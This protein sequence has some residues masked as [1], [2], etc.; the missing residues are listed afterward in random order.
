MRATAL[1]P[2]VF[3]FIVNVPA[4]GF[5]RETNAIRRQISI[6]LKGVGL[7]N[8]QSLIALSQAA[9]A[10]KAASCALLRE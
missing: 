5:V 2:R 9:C 8:C 4:V 6:C 1:K 3:Q 10:D 7:S